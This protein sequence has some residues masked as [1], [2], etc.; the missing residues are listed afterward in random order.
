MRPCHCLPTRSV[1]DAS[2]AASQGYLQDEPRLS[3][4]SPVLKDKQIGGLVRILVVV[5]PA[6]GVK[7]VEDLGGN[8]ALVTAAEAAVKHG[9]S[10][11][12]GTR[13]VRL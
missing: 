8:P 3:T 7:Q 11:L 13:P 6:G 9:G 4:C 5:T 12:L 1:R 2:P 10:S